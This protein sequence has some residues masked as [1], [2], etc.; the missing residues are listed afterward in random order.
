MNSAIMLESLLNAMDIGKLFE[1]ISNYRR[2]TWKVDPKE[3]VKYMLPGK[4]YTHLSPPQASRLIWE[5][6]DNV[7]IVDLRDMESYRRD[8]IMRSI[9]KPIDEF[10]KEIFDPNHSSSKKDARTILV[11]Y[12]GH[13]SKVAAAILVEEGFSQVHSLRGGMRRWNRWMKLSRNPVINK[14]PP[15]CTQLP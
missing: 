7:R 5:N 9:F 3:I 14:I 4:G 1:S 2:R 12:T 13:L 11:C 10:L 8:H 15:C 6:E